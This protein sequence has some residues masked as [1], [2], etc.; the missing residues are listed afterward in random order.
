MFPNGV[1]WFTTFVCYITLYHDMTRSSSILAMKWDNFV[2]LL[3]YGGTLE[4]NPL[5]PKGLVAADLRV[6]K[7]K[8]DTAKKENKK[9][10][11][12]QGFIGRLDVEDLVEGPNIVMWLNQHLLEGFGLTLEELQEEKSKNSATWKYIRKF[13][14]FPGERRSETYTGE[15][16]NKHLREVL[17]FLRFGPRIVGSVVVHSSTRGGGAKDNRVSSANGTCCFVLCC[18]GFF[19][20]VSLD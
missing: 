15:L 16:G 1:P 13:P 8:F 6:L 5:R 2:S 11:I 7:L 3:P 19:L 4:D 17:T 14:M 18:L 12:I 10:T 20:F 9:V